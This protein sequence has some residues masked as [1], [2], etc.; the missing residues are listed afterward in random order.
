MA[1]GQ[2]RR[3]ATR[4]RGQAGCAARKHVGPQIS[5]RR[6]RRRRRPLRVRF[7]VV[8]ELGNL[9]NRSEGP[10]LS[11]VRW[12]LVLLCPPLIKERLSSLPQRIEARRP[13]TPSIARIS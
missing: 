2:R 3:D 13:I 6:R 1:R 5:R 4:T 10:P 7:A 12:P 11:D 9:S 8:L